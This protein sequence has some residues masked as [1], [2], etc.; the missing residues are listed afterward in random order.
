M[1][2]LFR[3]PLVKAAVE[4]HEIIEE[5]NLIGL[6]KDDKLMKLSLFCDV[7][8]INRENF[9]TLWEYLESEDDVFA[10]IRKGKYEEKK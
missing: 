6:S 9:P 1:I 2:K 8:K 5:L 3:K 7:A 10:A 4:A